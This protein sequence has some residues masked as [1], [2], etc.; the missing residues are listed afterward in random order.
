MKGRARSENRISAQGDGR[1]QDKMFV[2][3]GARRRARGCVGV[4][5]V[6][7]RRGAVDVAELAVVVLELVHLVERSFGELVLQYR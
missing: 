5:P 1:L 2:S 3:A 7:V 4:R 6:D